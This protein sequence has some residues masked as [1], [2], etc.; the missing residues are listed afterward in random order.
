[1]I[2]LASIQTPLSGREVAS[3]I[4]ASEAGVREALDRLVVNGVVLR[5][6]IGRS[7]AHTLNRTH[8]AM[9]AIEAM[10]AMRRSVIEAAREIVSRWEIAPAHASLFGSFARRDGDTSSDLD[11]LLVHPSALLDAG[12]RHDRWEAQV[13]ELDDLARMTGNPIQ[14]LD[15][16][17]TALGEPT[18]DEA[19]TLASIAADEITL[20]GS[21]LDSLM[22]RSRAAR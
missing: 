16:P 18:A 6:P 9:P 20:T 13:A 3:R 15:L 22:R 17:D 14:I 19:A 12:D 8:V 4:G 2:E 7:Y 1:M 10:R 11:I 21:R 5:T